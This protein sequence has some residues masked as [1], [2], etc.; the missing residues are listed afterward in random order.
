MKTLSEPLAERAKI[1]LAPLSGLDFHREY[2]SR[3]N[4]GTASSH[5]TE[6]SPIPR[7]SVESEKPSTYASINER[8]PF[9]TLGSIGSDLASY[10]ERESDTKLKAAARDHDFIWVR[11]EHQFGKST[12]LESHNKWLGDTWSV[13]QVDLMACVRTND[14][15]CRLG[16]FKLIKKAISEWH[17]CSFAYGLEWQEL[18]EI[19]K[20]R[21]LAFLIDEV[22]ACHNTTLKELIEGFHGLLDACPERVKVIA[23]FM[24]GP[25][26]LLT[27][28]GLTNR[29]YIHSWEIVHLKAFTEDQVRQLVD[30]F[31]KDISSLLSARMQ[32]IKALTDYEPQRVQD[33]L[34]SGSL[35]T[36]IF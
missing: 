28:C 24:D 2:Y 15:V 30:L 9:I 25:I 21:R 5:D 11:G 7:P 8:S 20:Q 29:K 18:R 16:L 14:E 27:N 3:E 19:A 35:R 26:P 6:S 36:A 10:I 33:Q 4:P 22:G 23:S 1:D 31:P 17:P 12:L 32:P 13:V 34:L